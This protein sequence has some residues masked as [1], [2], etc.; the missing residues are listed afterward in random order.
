MADEI[1]KKC[2]FRVGRGRN[3]HPH[4]VTVE[5][6]EA[7]TFRIGG[8]EYSADLCSEHRAAMLECLQ[9]FIAISKRTG[10]SYSPRNARGRMV[11]RAKGGVTFTTKDVRRWLE[12]QGREVPNTGRLANEIIEEYKVANGL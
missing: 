12:E 3:I 9:P 11:M 2:D 10:R 8:V 4:G 5:G 6:N 7:T 1:I